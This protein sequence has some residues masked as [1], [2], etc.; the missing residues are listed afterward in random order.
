[1]LGP[2][3]V[4]LVL[5]RDHARPKLQQRARNLFAAVCDSTRFPVPA[6]GLRPLPTPPPGITNG[7]AGMEVVID[8]AHAEALQ[9]FY[10]WL[11]NKE[12][13]ACQAAI[14]ELLPLAS[15]TASPP[16]VAVASAEQQAP[17]APQH[18][19]QEV[20]AMCGLVMLPHA[21]PEQRA[22]F[23]ASATR[24]LCSPVAAMRRLSRLTINM[25]LAAPRGSGLPE[26]LPAT[27]VADVLVTVEGMSDAEWAAC[28]LQDKL[29]TGWASERYYASRTR[30]A[31]CPRAVAPLGKTAEDL[32]T[33]ATFVTSLLQWLVSDHKEA[34]A[35]GDGGRT[36]RQP[37]DV[38][39]SLLGPSRRWPSQ[40]G[41]GV[42]FKDFELGH[43]QLFKALTAH[44]GSAA[45]LPVFLPAVLKL[46]ADTKRDSQAVAAEAMAGLVRGA[47]RWP[48]S[49]QAALWGQL[50]E[51]LRATLR[52]CPVQSI[53]DWQ[54]C[55]RY[56][57]FNRD[58]RRIAWLV[59][60]LLADLEGAVIEAGD[61][62]LAGENGTEA[63][64]AE[65]SLAQA[66]HVRF[67]A[68]VVMELSWRGASLI[69][70]L[71]RGDVMRRW[72]TNPYRQ[73]R[74][75]VGS[76]LA[77][78]MDACTPMPAHPSAEV[79]A[80]R[81]EVDA[82][83]AHLVR[84]SRTPD[85]LLAVTTGGGGAMEPA[86]GVGAP[87]SEASLE[88]EDEATRDLARAARET[89]LRAITH[90]AMQS[91]VLAAVEHVPHILPTIMGAAAAMQRPDLSNAAK[92]CAV[93]MA[94][95][96]FEQKLLA[97]TLRALCALAT[98]GSWRMRG[99][100]LPFMG[101]IAYR[102][103][104]TEP[105]DEHAATMRTALLTLLADPQHEVREGS[106]LVLSGFIRLRGPTERIAT[107]R[108]AKQHTKKSRPLTDRH[109]G[110]LS[111]VA[112]LQLAPYD[113]P[114]WLPEVLELLGS[115][116]SEPQPI[117]AA[118][119]KAFA[120]FKRTHQDNWA[121]HRERFTTEQQ[122]MISDM[123]VSPS[124]YA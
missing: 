34:D 28:G 48:L 36:L 20:G 101:V 118:V 84:E 52:A 18:W 99:G 107:L 82:F 121:S 57:S 123:L 51:P 31:S 37:H 116:Y 13:I 1:M 55:L 106:A 78:A 49:E 80:I 76:L 91:R 114:S 14:A 29:T 45:L 81:A 62:S 94:H 103:Q 50:R 112:L 92:A 24:G 27:P 12:A 90:C 71:L 7:P 98:G 61:A 25:L 32:L 22:A 73:V 2:L 11:A 88:P 53:G 59:E 96:P 23:A 93:L 97:T 69:T 111:L 77:V 100:L 75:E 105:A 5:A 83:I 64:L 110:V 120:D 16:S 74:E 9:T 72:V 41:H 70:R 47:G 44:Y 19:S 58:P 43:A 8:P 68:P 26:L 10:A 33:D 87:L 35:D 102:S 86:V 46:A 89:T 38:V 6:P 117:K 21:L 109:A 3:L 15:P 63:A 39:V 56:M 119:S 79:I 42:E 60:L 4:A 95:F 104:F 115:F 124:F 67:I 65:T 66:N 108:W 17:S 85:E 40:P 30:G 113:V 54:A 122:E